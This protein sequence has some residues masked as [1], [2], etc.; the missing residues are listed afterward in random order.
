VPPIPAH[1]TTALNLD[2]PTDREH[3]SVRVTPQCSASRALERADQSGRVLGNV[4]PVTGTPD[5]RADYPQTR[6][7]EHAM[8]G[9]P[10]GPQSAAGGYPRRGQRDVRSPRPR[11]RR[12]RPSRVS[13]KRRTRTSSGV[14]DTEQPIPRV[15]VA[16]SV[17]DRG[18]RSAEASRRRGRSAVPDAPGQ[19]ITPGR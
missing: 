18:Y 3:Q 13:S 1:P 10:R 8:S 11:T 15:R 12:A 4:M 17:R 19:P 5:D 16:A 7:L 14:S 9:L 6:V 2:R